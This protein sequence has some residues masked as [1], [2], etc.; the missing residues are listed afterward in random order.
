MKK[1]KLNSKLSF[2]KE[3]ITKL[4]NEQMNLVNGGRTGGAD[5]C[6]SGSVIV[7]QCCSL[8]TNVGC[9]KNG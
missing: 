7:A 8:A 4:N 9:N 1:V 2:S 3:T 5:G 6:V